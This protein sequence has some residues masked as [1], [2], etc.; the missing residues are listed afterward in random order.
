MRTVL[1]RRLTVIFVYL[2][3][4]AFSVATGFGQE[5]KYISKL[6]SVWNIK[7]LT[8]NVWLRTES[9]LVPL[10]ITVLCNVWS[11]RFRSVLI[12][13]FCVAFYVV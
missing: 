6:M 9:N 10:Q 4:R 8:Y 11:H 13:Q 12:L 7:N 3:T 2:A 5:N 1:L